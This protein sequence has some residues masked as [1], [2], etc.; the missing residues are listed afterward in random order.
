MCNPI[1]RVIK[2]IMNN[3]KSSIA[4]HALLICMIATLVIVDPAGTNAFASSLSN[5]G[6]GTWKYQRK[7]SIEE[8]SGTTLSDYQV[9]IE[10]EGADFPSEKH[11]D[12]PDIRETNSKG[13][14]VH[15]ID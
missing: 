11:N 1:S 12:V 15:R 7:I 13:I 9:L 2:R 6:S 5:S 10:L 14:E 8:N 4:A 3:E